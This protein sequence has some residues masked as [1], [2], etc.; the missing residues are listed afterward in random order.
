MKDSTW[1]EKMVKG[2]FVL[3]IFF[4]VSY[5]VV[6][7]WTVFQVSK[8]I[9]HNGGVAKTI[10]TFVRDFECAKNNNCESND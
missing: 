2:I 1:I 8:E 6:A 10:G 7:I 9:D 5:F 4:M 3:V